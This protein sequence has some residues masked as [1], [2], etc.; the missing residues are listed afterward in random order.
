MKKERI[1]LDFLER[2][3]KNLARLSTLPHVAAKV[4]EMVENPR[5][6]ASTLAKII[7]SDQVLAARILRLAN[8]A[9]YGFPRKISTINLAIVVLGFNALRDLVLSIAVV[10]R[11]LENQPDSV[12]MDQFWRHALI[13]GMGARA[14]SRLSGYPVPGECFVTG[15]VH[16]I[17]YL[18]LVQHFSALFEEIYQVA[19]ETNCPFREAEKRVLGI[20]HSDI[21]AWLAEGWNL[22]EKLV[23]AVKYH[24]EPEK[25]LVHTD[26]VWIIHWA[27]KV[28]YTIGEGNG[29]PAEE[30]I[31][32][33]QVEQELQK[34]FKVNWPLAFYQRKFEE[35]SHK[36]NDFLAILTQPPKPVKRFESV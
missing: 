8:S 26:L 2:K 22:P 32:P 19:Q 4:T 31:D 12:D 28:S 29:F 27:D 23:Q 33:D 20:T 3:V 34:H 21:G 6:S 13:V 5:T 15:L 18:V 1:D 17:G 24:H 16:D 36:V 10:D 11:F 14:I 7:S 30:A 9:Y 35:E 25:A